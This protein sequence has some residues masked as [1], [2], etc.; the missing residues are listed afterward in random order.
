M[1]AGLLENLPLGNLVNEQHFRPQRPK[2]EKIKPQVERDPGARRLQLLLEEGDLEA[3]PRLQRV[4]EELRRPQVTFF[5]TNF[6]TKFSD[7]VFGLS[8]IL[9]CGTRLKK[10]INVYCGQPSWILRHLKA[11]KV[12]NYELK[13]DQ[14]RVSRQITAE[15]DYLIDDS[16]STLENIYRDIVVKIV[17]KQPNSIIS[18]F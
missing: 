13:F 2:I 8:F 15:T 11:V 7:K 3:A 17:Q 18:S 9:P 16:L 1:Q 5:R 12:H 4:Q 6:R 10:H 14:I